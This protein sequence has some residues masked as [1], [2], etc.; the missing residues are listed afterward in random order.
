MIGGNG[1]TAGA[2]RITKDV[3]QIVAELPALLEALTGV[4]F[5]E[6]VKRVPGLRDAETTGS[7]EEMS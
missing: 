6:L 2:S 1:A 3:T 5:D 7:A 4:K